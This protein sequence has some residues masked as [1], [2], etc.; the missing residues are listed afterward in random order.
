MI[1]MDNMKYEKSCGAIIRRN[2]EILLIKEYNDYWGKP[3]GHMEKGET[4][5]ETAIREI[6]EETNL[7]VSINKEKRYLTTY[8]PRKNT[9][10]DVIFFEAFPLND[11][12]VLEKD[13]ISDYNWVPKDEVLNYHMRDNLKEIFQKYFKSF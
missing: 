10:K 4:E 12:V 2:D 7:D 9:I 8:S 1:V 13:E 6:K 5:E 11:E 3:K